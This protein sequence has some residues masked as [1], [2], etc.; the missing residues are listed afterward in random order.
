MPNLVGTWIPYAYQAVYGETPKHSM[1]KNGWATL[2]IEPFGKGR[3]KR[4][5]LFHEREM[6]V[7]WDM[8]Y[9]D[10]LDDYLFDVYLADESMVITGVIKGNTF[11]AVVGT[12]VYVSGVTGMG[13]YYK[14][15]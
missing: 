7:S 6:N 15:A 13:V 14:R 1:W 2:E 3:A 11:E 8:R 12:E 4:K 10:E 5:V 9:V